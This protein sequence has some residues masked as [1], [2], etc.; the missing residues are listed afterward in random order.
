MTFEQLWVWGCGPLAGLECRRTLNGKWMLVFRFLAVL[1]A[2]LLT[3]G[4]LF[5]WWISAAIE[6][7]INPN[8][9]LRGTFVFLST[10]YL[11][12][13]VVLSPA[14][15]AGTLASEKETGTLGML[16]IAKV[17]AREIVLGRFM[18]RFC[19]LLAWMV[20]GWP[21]LILLAVLV[22]IRGIRLLALLGLMMT[23]AYGVCGL[24]LL[25]SA[26]SRR[27]RDAMLMVYLLGV[28][29]LLFLLLHGLVLPQSWVE[30][31]NP[32]DPFWGVD[33]LVR[34]YTVVPALQVMACWG[35][36]GTVGLVGAMWRLR[37]SYGK[38][39]AG[40]GS[41][42]VERRRMNRV[43][44]VSERPML[45]K[46]LY[47]ERSKTFGIVGQGISILLTTLLVGG[48]MGLACYVWW[49]EYY[50]GQPQAAGMGRLMM[51]YFVGNSA[52]FVGWLVQWLI[53][54]RAAVTIASER[55]RATWDSLLM[56]PLEGREIVVGKLWGSLYA[57]RWLVG[58]VLF[59]WSL[60]LACE[61]IDWG[62]YVYV[63]FDVL[64]VGAFMAALGLWLSLRSASTTTSMAQAILV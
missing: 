3:L 25:A 51:Q 37:P 16:L 23:V 18:G 58:S 64:G 27:G 35:A 48:S 19:Q 55:Q 61:A 1:P 31:L 53:G 17:S 34:A 33:G 26:L 20:A 52:L 32:L 29:W 36:L 40:S 14:L 11:L 7:K 38:L 46:E 56:S 6:P 60:A 47:I 15:L 54:L 45:W 28:C 49:F 42:K 10:L 12:A 62:M 24:S 43:P 5:V 57:M 63:V 4:I 13:A 59:A 30:F 22:D 9:M 50:A 8:D 2:G 39:I 41:S 44:P 21:C